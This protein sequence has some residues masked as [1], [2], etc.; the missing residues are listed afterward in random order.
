MTR[1]NHNALNGTPAQNHEEVGESGLKRRDFLR[2]AALTG[3]GALLPAAALVQQAQPA[4]AQFGGL[5]HG[6]VAILRFLAAAELVEFDLWQQYAELATNNPGYQQAVSEIDDAIPQY[7]RDTTNDEASHAAAINAFLKAMGEEPTNLDAFRTLPSAPVQGAQQIGR[8]TNLTNLTV[9][10]SWYNRYRSADN[11][12]FG[13]SIPQLLNIVNRAAVPTSDSMTTLQLQTAARVA[14][15]HFPTI[16]Q[17]GTSLYSALMLKVTNVNVLH[18]L[19]SIGPVEA[20]HFSIFHDALEDI[21]PFDSGDGLVIP[22]IDDETRHAVMPKPC[23]FLRPV[24]PLCSVVR[25]TSIHHGGAVA[26][27]NALISS[28][29]FQG[30]SQHFFSQFMILARL[31]DEAQRG[32]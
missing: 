32:L 10:T 17:G 29:L 18:I 26:A 14:A 5:P 20:V 25:P 21:Q 22:D 30:Q 28:N 1:F 6:D 13:D 31:A 8:L 9:D 23:K 7:S 11:P 2:N 4:Q 24:F 19:A 12:D 16:E 27:A 15:F 3:V